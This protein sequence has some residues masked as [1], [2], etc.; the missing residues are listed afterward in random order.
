MVGIKLS[1][2]GAIWRTKLLEVHRK[3]KSLKV[4]MRFANQRTYYIYRKPRKVFVLT[5]FKSL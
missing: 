4:R 2:K 5:L 1:V 3:E